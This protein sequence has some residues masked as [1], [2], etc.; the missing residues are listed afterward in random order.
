MSCSKIGSYL[1]YISQDD[2]FRVRSSPHHPLVDLEKIQRS[3]AFRPTSF[4]AFLHNAQGSS[5]YNIY[6]KFFSGIGP[7]PNFKGLKGGGRGRKAFA[8]EAITELQ[9][10]GFR[11]GLGAG[12]TSVALVALQSAVTGVQHWA[13]AFVAA[14]PGV[15][16][17][18][19]AQF[20]S[21]GELAAFKEQVM[22]AFVPIVFRTAPPGGHQG[23]ASS[24]TSPLGEIMAHPKLA[25]CPAPAGGAASVPPS[26]LSTLSSPFPSPMDVVTTAHGVA[27]ATGVGEA[28]AAVEAAGTATTAAVAGAGG[29][30]ES[31][32]ADGGG[33]AANGGGESKGFDGSA[34]SIS[35]SCST[36]VVGTAATGVATAAAADTAAAAA[37]ATT[38]GGGEAKDAAGGHSPSSPFPSSSPSSPGLEVPLEVPHDWLGFELGSA[39]VE[40]LKDARD[41]KIRDGMLEREANAARAAAPPA[42][43]TAGAAGAAG[44]VMVFARGAAAGGPS[45]STAWENDITRRMHSLPSEESAEFFKRLDKRLADRRVLSMRAKARASSN[46]ALQDGSFSCGAPISVAMHRAGERACVTADLNPRVE[47]H[48][49]A[50]ALHFPSNG[51]ADVEDDTS[52]QVVLVST[53][54][55]AVGGKVLLRQHVRHLDGGESKE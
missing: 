34:S 24:A 43:A 21:I 30:G 41:A 55:A 3:G 28:A 15:H 33:V 48:R 47:L 23:I 22:V 10:L 39:S 4:C 32:A 31:A 45:S 6:E 35:S 11:S 20:L 46:A 53:R 19:R 50:N 5:A 7:A 42:T 37:E 17:D 9:K 49:A 40:I 1:V 14:V 18:A 27:A 36:P 2:A 51:T 44:G 12:P 38:D 16:P 26:S 29:G 8:V 54:H 13:D 25:A 52:T